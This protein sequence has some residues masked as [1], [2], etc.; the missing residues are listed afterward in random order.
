MYKIKIYD[1]IRD[2]Y[3]VLNESQHNVRM[4]WAIHSTDYK[5]DNLNEK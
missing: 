3:G 2:Q 1:S 5:Y 4:I